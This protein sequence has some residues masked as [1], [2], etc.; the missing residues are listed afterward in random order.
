MYNKCGFCNKKRVCYRYGIPF[1]DRT[2]CCEPWRLFGCDH[3]ANCAVTKIGCRSNPQNGRQYVGVISSIAALLS[4]E[5]RGSS[6][7]GGEPRISTVQ[8]EWGL[9][10]G[11]QN[12]WPKWQMANGVMSQQMAILNNRHGVI[13]SSKTTSDIMLFGC[14]AICHFCQPF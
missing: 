12:A 8:S 4:V 5:F 2:C 10:S 13:A 6:G 7:L 11:F 14:F 1:A 3:V 9:Y